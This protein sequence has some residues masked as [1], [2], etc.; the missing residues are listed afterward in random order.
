MGCESKATCERTLRQ[1]A[2]DWQLPLDKRLTPTDNAKRLFTQ[3]QED[4]G[5]R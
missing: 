3:I 1:L 4:L 5:W 2:S